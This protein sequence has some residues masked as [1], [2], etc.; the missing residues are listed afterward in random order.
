MVGRR[1]R[2]V[3][4]RAGVLLVNW[5][6]LDRPGKGKQD[7]Q[8]ELIALSAGSKSAV[9]DFYVRKVASVLAVLVIGAM[10]TILCLLVY[11]PN[12]GQTTL[13]SLLRPG[14]GEGDRTE[15]LTVQIEDDD[16]AQTLEVTIQERKYTDEEKQQFLDRALEELD[17]LLLGEN[18]SPDAVRTSLVFPES[19]QDGAVQVDWMK[20]PYGIIGQDGS[21]VLADNEEGTLVE[22]QAT[23]ECDGLEAMYRVSV[24]VYPPNMTEEEQLLAAI[25]E[26]VIRADEESSYESE[27]VLPTL[28][29][30][31]EL[32]WLDESDNPS[33]YVLALTLVLTVCVYLR[34][35]NQV[36]EKAEERKKQ[37]LLDYPD[38]MW[39]MT[40]LLGAGMSLRGVFSRIS[41]EYELE[42][43][44]EAAK[45][46]RAGRIRYVY[47]EV[48]CTCREMQSGIG[49]AQAYERFGK[50]CQLPEYIRIGSVLS[51]NLRK[52]AKGL[53]ELLESEAET[54][55][56][57]RRNHARKIGEQAGTRLLLPMILMLG[58]VLAILMVPAFLSF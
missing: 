45:G 26:E 52:G 55:L 2:T 13:D 22:I 48:T 38:L 46:K 23:L 44:K 14:Y 15:E 6:G 36:H 58:I 18:E 34:M 54:S 49:E 47:E 25:R 56:I 29:A 11:G 51:Q 7:L 8:Q 32:L 53:T 57:D 40:M 20:S 33:F 17:E 9:T 16:E 3:F 43:N 5:L 28:A 39:K 12:R 19:L 41:E 37:L 35:D 42:K 50:R 31:K 24:M 27:L 1:I 4:N 30:G 21:I 10:L